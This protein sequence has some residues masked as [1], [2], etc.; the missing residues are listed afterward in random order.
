MNNTEA[1][2]E[3][4]I[5]RYSKL[6]NLS[7]EKIKSKFEHKT[8]DEVIEK[9]NKT[10]T[11]SIV[12][13]VIVIITLIFQFISL[14]LSKSVPLALITNILLLMIFQKGLHDNYEI[15]EILKTIR[16]IGLH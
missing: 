8:I 7:V 5:R 9:H 14:Y 13:V 2:R 16:E 3:I 15:K 11:L 10:I 12:L 6:S 1:V 4:L